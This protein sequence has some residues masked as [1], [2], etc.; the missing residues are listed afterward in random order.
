MY[1]DECCN[2]T[3]QIKFP[4]EYC[5]K[6]ARLNWADISW[7]I[8]HDFMIFGAAIDFAVIMLEQNPLLD[9]DEQALAELTLNQYATKHD[10][11]P[12]L[13]RLSAK[14]SPKERIDAKQK[15]LFLLLNWVYEHRENY[16]D[17]LYLV[18]VIF[19][20]FDFPDAL[21]P[22]IRYLPLDE[23]PLNSTVLNEERLL[24]HWKCY[25]VAESRKWRKEIS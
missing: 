15:I 14:T 6:N 4:L 10:V 19:D 7:A 16:P 5:M 1:T 12:P 11:F 21:K 25:L 17:P 20:D 8:Y 18:E 9:K 13:L 22:F 23:P 2:N 24:Q 3:L